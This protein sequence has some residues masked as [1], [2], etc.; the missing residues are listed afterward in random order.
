VR[1]SAA[2]AA[3]GLF[4]ASG[5]SFAGENLFRVLADAGPSVAAKRPG[6]TRMLIEASVS[7]GNEG[8]ETAGELDPRM[9]RLM[10]KASQNPNAR[11]AGGETLL[12]QAAREGLAEAVEL[13]LDKGADIGLRDDR[14]RTALMHAASGGNA[15]VVGLLLACGAD[16]AAK[17]LRGSTA[18]DRASKHPLALELLTH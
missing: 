9:V 5:I 14:G 4:C 12:M 3:V 11:S 6:L 7:H 13:L 2:T 18:R 8:S 10:V 15:E 16:P 17:D 1:F